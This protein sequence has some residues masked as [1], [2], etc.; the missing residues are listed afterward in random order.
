MTFG[1][2]TTLPHP[3]E[4]ALERVKQELAKEGFG[5][6]TTIDMRETFR[7][8]LGVEFKKYV[9]LGAC[10][11][12]LAMKALQTEEAVGLLLPCNVI[13]SEKGGETEVTGFDPLTIS[14]LL[15][16]PAVEELA[17]EVRARIERVLNALHGTGGVRPVPD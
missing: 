8:K 17:R 12:A 4:E 5:V 11:P 3:Y 2:S 16:N 7:A 14:A 10:N 6:I 1:L 15:A 9:I 13:V